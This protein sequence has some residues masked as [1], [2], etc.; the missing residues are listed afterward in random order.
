MIPGLDKVYEAS[1]KCNL[2]VN[3][4]TDLCHIYSGNSAG[5]IVVQCKDGSKLPYVRRALR[6]LFGDADRSIADVH[7]YADVFMHIVPIGGVMAVQKSN[8]LF[9]GSKEDWESLHESYVHSDLMET[10]AQHITKDWWV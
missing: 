8:V 2:S 1:A 7:V 5:N 6:M 4:L 3:D 10:T 9:L